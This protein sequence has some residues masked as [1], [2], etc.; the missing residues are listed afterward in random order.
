MDGRRPEFPAYCL[1]R[2]EDLICSCW[3]PIP[4]SRPTFQDI[5]WE[6]DMIVIESA[7]QDQDGR[8]FWETFFVGRSVVPWDHFQNGVIEWFE[9]D[10]NDIYGQEPKLEQLNMRCLQELLG[11]SFYLL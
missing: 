8:D 11:N 6:L 2:L 5:I 4:E 1:P 9:L 3:D 10:P 7:I